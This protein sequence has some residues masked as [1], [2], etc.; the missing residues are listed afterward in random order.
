MDPWLQSPQMRRFQPVDAM[1]TQG[2]LVDS[3]REQIV[4]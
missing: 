4:R 2:S 3:E 1:A